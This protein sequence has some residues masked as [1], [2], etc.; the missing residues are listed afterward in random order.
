MLPLE[1]YIHENG[2]RPYKAHI[3]GLEIKVYKADDNTD[4]DNNELYTNLVFHKMCESIWVGKS[5][6]MPMTEF[7]GGYGQ[8]YDGNTLLVKPEDSDSYVFIGS[9]IQS[10]VPLHPIVD[11]I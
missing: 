6:I 4:E 3:Q 11:F 1:Y 9:L 2:G 10:F 5:P 8:E 7:S